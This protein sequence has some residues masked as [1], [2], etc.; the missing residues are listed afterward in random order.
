M[1]YVMGFFS[2]ALSLVSYVKALFF[3]V[4]AKS[5]FEILSFALLLIGIIFLIGTFGIASSAVWAS[6]A[7]LLFT[8]VIFQ[9]LI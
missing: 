6:S 4:H 2:I 3:S 8:A 9:F 5:R 7:V 1:L